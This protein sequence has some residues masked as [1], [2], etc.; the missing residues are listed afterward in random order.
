MVAEDLDIDGYLIPKG[1]I[2][3]L[4]TAAANHDADA[5]TEPQT[6]DITVPREPQLTFGGGPHYCLGAALAR[7]EMQEA[8]PILAANLPDLALDGEPA[9][10]QMVGIYG[11]DSLPIRFTSSAVTV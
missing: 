1:T 6:F 7:A 4:S 11:P 10:R 3:M 8:L 2:L 5:Y 9:W